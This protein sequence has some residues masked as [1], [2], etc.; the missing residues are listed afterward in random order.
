MSLQYVRMTD[1]PHAPQPSPNHQ[2]C[3]VHERWESPEEWLACDDDLYRQGYRNAGGLIVKAVD[4][5]PGEKG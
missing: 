1:A 5:E 2:W 4:P 3:G